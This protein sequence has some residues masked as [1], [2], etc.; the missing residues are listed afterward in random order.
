MFNVFN[1]GVELPVCFHHHQFLHSL[2]FV[3]W[4]LF[5]G[6]NIQRHIWVANFYSPFGQMILSFLKI[7]IFVWV[8]WKELCVHI[9]KFF[10][11]KNIFLSWEIIWHSWL[12][13]V[14]VLLLPV[15]LVPVLSGEIIWHSWLPLLLVLLLSVS[16]PVV[17]VLSG[18]II[19]HSWLL[20]LSV[21]LLPFVVLFNLFALN[22]K[23]H[24]KLLL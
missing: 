1:K 21:L 12:L 5:L 9:V 6:R 20:L 10:T 3:L 11:K 14:S 15:S 22:T 24:Y 13:L 7:F 16:L 18:E 23:I 4:Y 8:P 19:W 2:A 17:P